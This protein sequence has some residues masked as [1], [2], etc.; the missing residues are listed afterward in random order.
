MSKNEKTLT[1]SLLMVLALA[2]VPT[3]YGASVPDPIVYLS[4]N[5]GSG[6]TTVNS[7]TAGGELTLSTPMPMWSSNVPPSGGTSSLDF[8]TT[9]GGYYAESLDVISELAGLEK[10]T[11]TFWVNCTDSTEGSGGNRLVCWKIGQNGDGLDLVYLSNGGLHM[12]VNEWPDYPN[13][14]PTRSSEGMIPTDAAAG[15][16]N[17]RFIALTY[18]STAGSDHVTYY[19]GTPSEPAAKDMSCTYPEGGAVGTNIQLLTIGNFTGTDR[20]MTGRQFRGLIDEV[21]IFGDALT[22]EQIQSIQTGTTGVASGPNPPDGATDVSTDV[23]GVSWKP[24]EFANTHN[25][26]LGTDFDDVND[27]TI[28]DPLGTTVYAGLVSD[29]NRVSPGRLAY[30]TTYYWRVDEVNAAPDYTVFGGPVWSFTTE[31]LYYT[32]E[33]VAVTASVPTGTG[34]GDLHVTVDSSGLTDGQHGTGDATMWSGKGAADDPVWIQYDFDRVYKLY[35]MHVWNYNGLYEY[36]LGFG[37]KD[38]TIEYATEP[39]EWQVL[40][41]FQLARA[42]SLVTYAGQLIDLDGLAARSIRI[43]VN[44]THSGGLQAGLSE[45]RFLYKPVV[46]RAP[47]PADGATEVSV[48]AGLSWRA[49]REAA[50]HQVQF[51]TDEQAVIDGTAL[52]DTVADNHF[53]PGALSL[54]TR[55]FWRI[56]EVNEA[57]V[58]SV[59]ASDVWGFTTVEYFAVDGFENYSG[60]EGQEVFSTWLDGYN[61]TTNGSQAGHDL[62]PY[63]ERTVVHSGLQSMPL[64]YSN[65]GSA[66][67]SEV[68]RTFDAAQDWTGGGVKSLS[69]W[70][71]GDPDNTGQLYVKINNKKVPYNG[72][73]SNITR[74]QWQPWNID[75]SAIGEN[76]KNIT[77]LTIGVEGA[78]AAGMIYVDDIRLYPKTPE[79]IVPV[80][81]GKNGLLAE[82][83]FANG[84]TDSSGQGHNGTFLGNAYA[85]DSVLVLDGTDDAVSIPRLGGPNATFNRCTYSM[86]MYSVPE[87]ATSGFI[88]GINSN[89]WT[90]GGIHCKIVDGHANAGINALAGGDMNGRTIVGPDEWFHLALTVSDTEAAIYLNGQREDSRGFSTP[91]VM[92]LGNGC[93]GAY[94]DN[95]DI[96]RELTGK[97]D[98]VRIYDRAVSEAEL[99]WLAGAREPVQKPF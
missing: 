4:F 83:L 16:D 49:G 7:G 37:L 23:G 25:V 30:S 92:Y 67:T 65:T 8:G 24:S 80:D 31:P 17:W 61:I 72:S 48:N 43:N 63:V 68:T 94:S 45:I 38:I 97:M 79:M 89:N 75:L 57:A 87:P 96:Q 36:V 3:L 59:W 84:A 29:A 39:D 82:Y 73:A 56:D 35:Q 74:G 9:A 85:A 77:K 90:T 47:Q 1:A 19:F 34:S 18:D 10:F 33:K 5:E 58:P 81:P 12:A 66:T 91:L 44:S 51:S 88:G 93:I 95:G 71:Y 55:Y 98:D 40:G 14:R 50:A 46:A 60:D 21:R 53:S 20:G 11:V 22:L 13:N 32:V 15:A 70:F 69:L 62:P 41:D 99:L 6:T 52:V 64:L 76:L 78:G 2:L 28:A 42:T 27:A 86:W 54:G 26:F